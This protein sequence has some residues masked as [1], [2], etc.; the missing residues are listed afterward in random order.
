MQETVR[1]ILYDLKCLI[2]MEDIHGRCGV[3]ACAAGG[4]FMRRDGRA[5]YFVLL[6]DNLHKRYI[7][8]IHALHKDRPPVLQFRSILLEGSRWVTNWTLLIQG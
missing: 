7:T 4:D 2:V 1:V 3:G 6:G 8:L 5:S